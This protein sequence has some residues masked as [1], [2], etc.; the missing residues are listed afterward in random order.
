[1]PLLLSIRYCYL[2]GCLWFFFFFINK[3]TKCFTGRFMTPR[4]RRSNFKFTNL[5]T[6]A[7]H[8]FFSNCFP[9]IHLAFSRY[10]ELM[11]PVNYGHFTTQTFC[12]R[13]K[14]QTTYMHRRKHNYML[15]YII[16][17]NFVLVY[18]LLMFFMFP[19]LRYLL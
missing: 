5:S 12:W 9:C 16:L 15:L 17:W 13:F 11:I 14:F 18:P 8:F 10:L 19:V 4:I 3:I 1:M 2:R 6:T 7:V